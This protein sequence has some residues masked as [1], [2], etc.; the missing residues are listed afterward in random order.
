MK[1]II[2]FIILILMILSFL[3]VSLS[4]GLLQT[5]NENNQKEFD[6]HFMCW[7]YTDPLSLGYQDVLM[8]LSDGLQKLEEPISV[9]WTWHT[10]NNENECLIKCGEAVKAG[11]DAV[12]SL[13]LS[14]EICDF[15]T[16]EEV[17]FCSYTTYE[18]EVEE[19]CER[20][21]FY[22]GTVH[23]DFE[24]V[25]SEQINYLMKN[26]CKEILLVGFPPGLDNH[27]VFWSAWKN[28]LN[29]YPDVTVHEYRGQDR[30][31]MI[32][33]YLMLYRNID[34]ICDTSAAGGFG[35]AMLEVLEKYKYREILHATNAEV[36]DTES[37]FR[38][39]LISMTGSGTHASVG[40]MFIIVINQL[41]GTPLS[42]KPIIVEWP[43]VI[44]DS[45]DTYHDF[46]K[47]CVEE[48]FFTFEEYEPYLKWINKNASRDELLMMAKRNSLENVKLRHSVN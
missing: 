30:A 1:R 42:D 40:H 43:F 9:N 13:Y 24:Q 41:M 36:V 26:G 27:D 33:N 7:A 3:F 16:K 38:E 46:Q 25:A 4:C 44:I 48:C 28:V 5:K 35:D 17:Y 47:Y 2:V 19:Y 18:N 6:I 15:L 32:E 21:Q 11:A 22:L 34:G 37:A 29:D 12:F 31:D 10:V 8:M 20:S 45:L 39:N 14:Y 23:E